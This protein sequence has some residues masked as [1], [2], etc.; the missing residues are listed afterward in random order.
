M[1]GNMTENRIIYFWYKLSRVT[2]KL[3]GKC[4][5]FFASTGTDAE[6]LGRFEDSVTSLGYATV[7]EGQT[8]QQVFE[9]Y[10]DQLSDDC[11]RLGFDSMQ[12]VAIGKREYDSLVRVELKAI[13][14][15][16]DEFEAPAYVGKRMVRK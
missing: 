16:E 8:G 10:K 12:L 5:K 9:L 3:T 7:Y 13:E 11:E 6:T 1:D 4:H 14:A 2:G 15:F